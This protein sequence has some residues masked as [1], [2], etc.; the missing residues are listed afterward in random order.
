MRPRRKYRFPYILEDE[1]KRHREYADRLEKYIE[2]ANEEYTAFE[3]IAK[4][5]KKEKVSCAE[6]DKRT[7]L[8]RNSFSN[9]FYHRGRYS[10]E[11]VEKWLEALDCGLFIVDK[12]GIMYRL[13][14]GS[15]TKGNSASYARRK[16]K[17]FNPD[18]PG[19]WWQ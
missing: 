14:R 19:V 15:V 18:D 13:K 9:T 6:M 2:E 5:R 8:T 17:E 12:D 1:I 11:S 4:I 7:G 10:L 3:A 16:A